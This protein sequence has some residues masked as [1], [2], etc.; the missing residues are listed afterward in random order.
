MADFSNELDI[1]GKRNF[2]LLPNRFLGLESLFYYRE[3]ID[4]YF[5]INISS[6]S[7]I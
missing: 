6:V 7:F 5:V 3:L 4:C 1:V 2:S